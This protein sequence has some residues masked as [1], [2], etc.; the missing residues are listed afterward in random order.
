M[1]V[2]L[3]F[4]IISWIVAIIGTAHALLGVLVMFYYH[5]TEAGKLERAAMAFVR[6]AVPTYRWTP[7]IAAIVAWTAIFSFR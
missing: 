6:G 3:F 7:L 5:C 4:K 2:I 1:D